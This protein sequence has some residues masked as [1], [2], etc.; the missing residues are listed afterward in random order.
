MIKVS[1]L[2]NGRFRDLD[3]KTIIYP[4]KTTSLVLDAADAFDSFLKNCIVNVYYF[5]ESPDEYLNIISVVNTLKEIGAEVIQLKIAYMPNA[6]MDRIKV[7]GESFTLRDFASII[8]GLPIDAVY[9]FDPHSP[10][11]ELLLNKATIKTKDRMDWTLQDAITQ[12][13]N[14]LFSEDKKFYIAFPDAGA[15][16][17]YQELIQKC[18][19]DNQVVGSIIGVKDK[20]WATGEIKEVFTRFDYNEFIE[21]ADVLIIDD[22]C[23]RGG[24]FKYFI[25]DAQRHSKNFKFHLYVSHLE[26]AVLEGDLLTDKSLNLQ[27]IL[28]TNSLAYLWW[29]QEKNMLQNEKI[30][31]VELSL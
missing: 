22:I 11:S 4:D 21:D 7:K 8:N 25:K 19:F 20:D 12:H 9:V 13:V 6:R 23:S 2:H 5:Y 26:P 15:Q 1:V 29:R 24:T 18:K 31:V 10:V 28:T 30:K 16:K 14:K 3:I 27:N 17:R